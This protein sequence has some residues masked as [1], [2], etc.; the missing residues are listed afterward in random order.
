[1]RDLLPDSMQSGGDILRNPESFSFL[2]L[3]SSGGGL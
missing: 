3:L 1:M 2:I